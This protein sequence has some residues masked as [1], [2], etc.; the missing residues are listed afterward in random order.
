MFELL[1]AAAILGFALTGILALYMNCIFL[2]HS[3]NDSIIAMSHAQHIMEELKAETGFT[4]L[5]N[6]I[7]NG[8]YETFSNLHGESTTVCCCDSSGNC[9]G[10]PCPVSA[11]TDPQKV[12]VTV[13]WTETA[14]A[15]NRNVKLQTLFTY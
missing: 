2:N 11:Q 13:S 14:R 6:I 4:D 10:S 5:R 12:C 9:P 3:S 1:V 15:H 7:N 8:T